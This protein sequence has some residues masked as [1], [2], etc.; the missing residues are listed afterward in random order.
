MRKTNIIDPPE[1]M[2]KPELFWHNLKVCDKV[3]SLSM[4][5]CVANHYFV[6]FPQNTFQDFEKELR[7]RE[8]DTHIIAA[9][10]TSEMEKV[11]GC[12]FPI[13]NT[14]SCDYY[15]IFSC[16][17]RDMALK[18]L[19][20]YSKDYN[21]NFEKLKRT[22]NLCVKNKDTKDIESIENVKILDPKMLS[23]SENKMQI[24][25]IEQ[26][27]RSFVKELFEILEKK[28]GGIKVKCVAFVDGK[29]VMGFFSKDDII[30]SCYGYSYDVLNESYDVLMLEQRG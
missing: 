25:L 28:H 7:Q 2:S 3:L 30:I 29:P 12:K 21:E 16:R 19:K 20:M 14:N 8:F 11:Y 15:C 22:G 5:I 24:Q 17:K 13:E 26:D 18:E 1:D 27:N 10:L 23:L 9:S 6:L 4:F